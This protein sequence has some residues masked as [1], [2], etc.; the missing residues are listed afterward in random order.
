MSRS[1][2]PTLLEGA[3]QSVIPRKR[4]SDVALTEL[5]DSDSDAPRPK[6]PRLDLQHKHPLLAVN[7][8]LPPYVTT[9]RAIVVPNPPVMTAPT[10]SLGP[11]MPQRTPVRGPFPPQDPVQSINDLLSER[12]QAA[13]TLSQLRASLSTE[14]DID[15]NSASDY[16]NAW[17]QRLS[18]VDNQI[19][20][21]QMA[22]A[23]EG[24]AV[25]PNPHPPF[26]VP[27]SAYT[28]VTPESAPPETTHDAHP[29]YVENEGEASG[30]DND[31]SNGHPS[32]P[33]SNQ[34]I[35]I[36]GS[37]QPAKY[38]GATECL[39]YYLTLPIVCRNFFK[40]AIE[41]FLTLM[42]PFKRVSR[43]S[44]CVI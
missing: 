29:G 23:P 14:P 22:A 41:T 20:E 4:N 21:V 17:Q 27:S 18:I 39:Q 43:G 34:A 40:T 38:V 36:A 11:E 16:I 25:S 3:R 8:N 32:L 26:L 12:A 1:S 35:S 24:F 19:A 30:A 28:G 6:K 44:D 37:S 31:Q 33:M 2:R 15:R 42:L 10:A 9:Q 5:S 13:A 7:P